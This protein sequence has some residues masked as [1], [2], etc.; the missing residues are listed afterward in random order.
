M[1][2]IV[3]IAGSAGAGL[4]SRLGGP[5]VVEGAGAVETDE[6]GNLQLLE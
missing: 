2:D 1:L 3:E 6:V 4:A 5:G